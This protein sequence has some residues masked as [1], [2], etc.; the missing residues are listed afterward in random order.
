[1]GQRRHS[2]SQNSHKSLVRGL[3]FLESIASSSS[4]L[5]ITELADLCGVDKSTV[6]RIIATLIDIGFVT[7][8]E[9]RR[10]VLTGRVLSFAKGFEQQYSLTEVASPYLS[11]LRDR[12]NETIILTGR[13]GDFTVGLD[14]KDPQRSFRMVPHVGIT[15]PLYATAAGRAIMFS[16]PMPDQKRILTE[17]ANAPVEDEEVRLSI[18]E[19]PIELDRARKQGFVWLPRTDD[20]ERVAAVAMGRHG[21][22]LAA[23]SIY[24]PK[25][26]MTARITELGREARRTAALIAKAAHGINEFNS[27][28]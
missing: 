14:Q 6:S 17:L 27:S 2:L 1:M 12:I 19:W 13:Q 15:A 18:S 21:M 24:G 25:H 22:P 3:I 7:R 16:L 26:R 4:G 10:I 28:I 20:V 8:L 9:N 11:D 5:T 23:V